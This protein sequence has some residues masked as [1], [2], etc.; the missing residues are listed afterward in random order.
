MLAGGLGLLT[1][2]V[3]GLAVVLAALP[4]VRRTRTPDGDAPN[5]P[6]DEHSDSEPEIIPQPGTA[7]LRER[8]IAYVLLAL[9]AAGVLLPFAQ[10][11]LGG[12]EQRYQAAAA[13]TAVQLSGQIAI[14]QTRAS[15][16]DDAQRTAIFA[17]AAATSRQLAALD[18]TGPL[19]ATEESI[20]SGEETAAARTGVVAAQ[21]G[22][23][24]TTANGIDGHLADAL[25]RV[26]D[27]WKPVERQQIEQADR[28]ETFGAWSNATVAFIAAVAALGAVVEVMST[29]RRLDP[30]PQPPP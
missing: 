14:G 29:A 23:A 28:A 26:P 10:L 5:S 11:T 21:M 3:T 15:F 2:L 20:A 17:D 27:D 22:A 25:A 6:D 19:V 13:R 18:V 4:R 1:V 9:W 30:E 16:A 8:R 12:E 7:G 24:P